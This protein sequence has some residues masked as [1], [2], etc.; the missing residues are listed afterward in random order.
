MKKKVIAI[1]VMV[2]LVMSMVAC[3]STQAQ[4]E[5]VAPAPKVEQSKEE[6]VVEKEVEEPSS[7]PFAPENLFADMENDDNSNVV[8]GIDYREFYNG[9]PITRVITEQATYNTL[10]VIVTSGYG[11]KNETVEMTL[12]DGDSLLMESEKGDYAMYYY[13]PKKVTH[14]EK[15]E[16]ND[17]YLIDMSEDGGAVVAAGT[18][19]KKGENVPTGIK[20]TYEDGTEDSITIY[21]TKNY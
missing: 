4:P 18:I 1:V 11:G 5:T 19:T 6:P 10:K 21:V 14:V 3:G 9:V 7:D 15:L 17:E 8:D 13:S 12:S 20:V 2:A 16:R